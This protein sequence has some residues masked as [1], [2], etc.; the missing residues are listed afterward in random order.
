[1]KCIDYMTAEV[2]NVLERGSCMIVKINKYSST[3]PPAKSTLVGVLV[4]GCLAEQFV[5]SQV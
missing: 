4:N 5:Q 1:M 3:T 2:S